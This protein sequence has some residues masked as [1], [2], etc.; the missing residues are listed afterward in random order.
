MQKFLSTP[1]AGYLWKGRA[2]V[3]EKRNRYVEAGRTKD[4]GVDL[5][6]HHVASSVT[7][8]DYWMSGWGWIYCGWASAPA[9]LSDQADT[10]TETQQHTC[11]W[12]FITT[13][14]WRI[15]PSVAFSATRMQ[16]SVTCQYFSLMPQATLIGTNN[17]QYLF[18][19][20]VKPVIWHRLN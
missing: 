16:W 15:T 6:R 20:I 8:A 10:C 5:C 3:H 2:N 1:D 17:W 12:I 9:K 14:W 18:I 19:E 11:S 4:D 13:S 7:S